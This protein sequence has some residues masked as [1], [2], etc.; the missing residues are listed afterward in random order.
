MS[1][2]RC[3]VEVSLAYVFWDL[4]INIFSHQPVEI[5]TQA[6]DIQWIMQVNIKG[7]QGHVF[8]PHLN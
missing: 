4:Y 1:Q 8:A 3:E 2:R 7:P 6:L 5:N